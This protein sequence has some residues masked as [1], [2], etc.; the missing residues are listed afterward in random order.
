MKN[1]I[2]FSGTEI[3]QIA[4]ALI[5]LSFA[6]QL[7]IFRKEI[8]TDGLFTNVVAMGSFFLQALAIVGLGFV[9]HELGHK[10]V[11]QKKGLWAEFRAWPAG[12]LLAVVMALIS[13]GGFVFAAPGAVMIAP[14]KKTKRGFELK[15][16]KKQ[17]IGLIGIIGSV[18]NIVLAMI[19]SLLAL[20]FTA[21]IFG[22]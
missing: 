9:L 19:F 18:I 21:K 2:H 5:A 16:L 7:I 11:A 12:L 22:I 14:G 13:K 1:K 4:L 6:F 3:K 17:D 8:F 15:V 10:F 20:F